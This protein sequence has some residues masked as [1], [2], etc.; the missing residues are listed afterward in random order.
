MPRPTV[1]RRKA[2]FAHRIGTAFRVACSQPAS[3]WSPGCDAT[4]L[5]I[6]SLGT[7]V[8]RPRLVNDEP[9]SALSLLFSR[10][11]KLFFRTSGNDPMR[12]AG[13]YGGPAI[14]GRATAPAQG[15]TCNFT[16]T[17]ASITAATLN[18]QIRGTVTNVFVAACM[19]GFGGAYTG[20]PN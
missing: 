5:A 3:G 7:S 15:G 17:P 20:R 18:I 4:G 10:G 9:N 6:G 11:A 1:A 16:I 13:N 19:V 2:A 8:Y 14:T 12:G